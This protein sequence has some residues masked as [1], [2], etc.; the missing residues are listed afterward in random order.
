MKNQIC[1]CCGQTIKAKRERVVMPA[2]TADMTDAQLYAHYKKTSPVEDV[3]FF[4]T[5]T[6]LSHELAHTGTI[7][8][9]AAQNGL[10]RSDVLWQ[11][12]C[13]QDEWRR[14]SNAAERTSV[15]VAA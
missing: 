8:L 15:A 13:L 12:A 9:I 6:R 5:H 7:L 2:N 14:A 10:K 1:E 4:L 11:L 3:R